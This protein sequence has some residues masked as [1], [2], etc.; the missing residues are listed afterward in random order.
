MA[1]SIIKRVDKSNLTAYTE[2]DLDAL[3][4]EAVEPWILKQADNQTLESLLSSIG[5]KIFN[6]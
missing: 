3:R 6:F 2:T 4:M 5:I 1:K